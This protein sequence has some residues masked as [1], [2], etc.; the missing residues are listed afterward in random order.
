MTLARAAGYY[1]AGTVEFLVDADSGEWFF[2][3]VNPRVQVEHTVTEMVT[4][5]DIV[6]AQILVAQGRQAAR[7]RDRPAAAGRRPAARLRA[8]VPRDDRRSGQQLHAR[9]RQDP[10]LS[11]ACRIRHSARRRIG[12]WRR[13][14]HAVLRFAAGEGDGVGPRFP[15]G[16]PAHGPGSARVPH[17]RRKDEH[18]VPRKRG[19]SPA[20]FRPAMSPPRFLDE[21]PELFQFTPRRDRATKLLTYLG[22]VIVN[23]NHGSRRASRK[24]PT[25]HAAPVP[26]HDPSRPPAGTRQLLTNWGPRSSPNGRA[27]QE[28]LLV[29]RHDVSRCAPVADGDA[30]AHLRHAGDRRISSRTDC[31]TCTA[32]RCGAARP[33]MSRMRFLLRRSVEAAAAR[34]ARRFRTSVSRCC[35]ARR[36]RS[37]TRLIP[38]TSCAE[39]IDEAAAQG[40]DIFRIFDSLNWLPNMQVAMEA[41]REDRHG[42]AKPRSATPAISSIRSATSIRCNYYVRMA[43]E[44]EKMGA[45][46]LAIKDMAGLL[47]AVRGVQAG[48]GAARR[49]RHCRFTSTRTTPAASMRPPF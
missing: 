45:H 19:E 46:I 7:T 49:D 26:P 47:Q 6:R 37:D 24:P 1:N 13:G 16:V 14:D 30:R 34:C 38:T 15:E 2:I 22:D 11:L 10:H 21:T 32:W 8:A 27:S 48:E 40:I 31:T 23:G 39:F 29:H 44:L 28:R 35:C 12:L 36:T 25:L 17:P 41:V 18:S 9:L 5:I 33:S 4:G 43:K 3:E 20:T 42:S